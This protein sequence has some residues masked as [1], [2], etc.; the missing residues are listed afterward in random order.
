MVVDRHSFIKSSD[1]K[2][3]IIKLA[4]FGGMLFLLMT[5]LCV[6]MYSAEK[7]AYLSGLSLAAD[8]KFVVI[9]DSR[10]A[11]N[12]DPAIIPH[13]K[14]K[15]L[16]GSQIEEWKVILKDLIEINKADGIKRKVIVEA[17]HLSMARARQKAIANHE[18]RFAVLWFIHPELRQRIH[19]DSLIQRYVRS[20]FPAPF[21]AWLVAVVKK[22]AYT[23]NV[24]C[25]FERPSETTGFSSARLAIL[26]QERRKTDEGFKLKK[27][28]LAHLEEIKSICDDAGWEL[29]VV[30]FPVLGWS[31]NDKMIV[32]FTK[33]CA[34]WCG[35]KKIEYIDMTAMCEDK[36]LW[37]DSVHLKMPGAKMVSE[38][39]RDRLKCCR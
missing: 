22:R 17:G 21:M 6:V 7:K 24:A 1:M 37:V 27:E 18:H 9:G 39:V 11:Q 25:G 23:G 10:S 3:F 2:S 13:L 5:T 32:D 33:R 34:E 29:V 8:D 20:E 14:N 28:D 16:S 15:S 36:D 38:Y 31:G 26:A 35:G 30:T 19:F 4:A 12:L